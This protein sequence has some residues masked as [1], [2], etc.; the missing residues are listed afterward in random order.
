MEALARIVAPRLLNDDHDIRTAPG[1]LFPK[2]DML[3][4]HA[5]QM[6]AGLPTALRSIRISCVFTGDQTELEFSRDK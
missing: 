5:G 4:L 6:G 1:R 2:A 3:A